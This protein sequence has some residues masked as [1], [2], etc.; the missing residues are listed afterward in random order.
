M[1]GTGEPGRRRGRPGIATV[2]GRDVDRARADPDGGPRNGRLAR[3]DA[4]EH[5]KQ[6][7]AELGVDPELLVHDGPQHPIS[8]PCLVERRALVEWLGDVRGEVRRRADLRHRARLL[9]D[10]AELELR[11][12]VGVAL[13]VGGTEQ[14]ADRVDGD[15]A[16]R[17]ERAQPILGSGELPRGEQGK[18]RVLLVGREHPRVV[19]EAG[20][21]EPDTRQESGRRGV[22][23][24]LLGPA[25]AQVVGL[26]CEVSHVLLAPGD[27]GSDTWVWLS[28]ARRAATLTCSSLDG[29]ALASWYS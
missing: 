11:Q 7:V 12:A 2:R 25:D 24:A 10:R 4:R 14:A 8:T 28:S 29:F 5:L 22:H 20:A 27:S 6:P 26:L 13:L 15:V 9:F 18:H 16:R 21:L 3:W 19:R 17:S 1:Q 23:G